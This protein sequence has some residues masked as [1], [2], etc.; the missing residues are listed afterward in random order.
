MVAATIKQVK[1]I[2]GGRRGLPLWVPPSRNPAKSASATMR[3]R[4]PGIV[5]FGHWVVFLIPQ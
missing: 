5:F 1:Q 3:H 4:L 2:D